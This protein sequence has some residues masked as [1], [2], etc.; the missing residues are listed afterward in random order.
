MPEQPSW[1]DAEGAAD[2][3]TAGAAVLA[4]AALLSPPPPPETERAARERALAQFREAPP[5]PRP[6]RPEDGPSAQMR[7]GWAGRLLRR[8]RRK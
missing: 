6:L 2:A 8:L 7:G 1:P 5:S 4:R 3:E